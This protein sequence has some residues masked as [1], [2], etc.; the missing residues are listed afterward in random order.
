MMPP[1]MIIQPP[2]P[3][4]A[5]AYQYAY[6]TTAPVTQGTTSVRRVTSLSQLYSSTVATAPAYPQYQYAY[7]TAAP[8]S[9]RTV[10]FRR[11]G[12]TS[13]PCQ[14]NTQIPATTTVQYAEYPT[15]T[16]TPQ[17]ATTSVTRVVSASQM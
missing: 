11:V 10:S 7:P 16:Q 2:P 15:V 8:V 3:P 4:Q 12:S 13:Q 14:V 5:P 1:P 9:Q 6:Q 17:G